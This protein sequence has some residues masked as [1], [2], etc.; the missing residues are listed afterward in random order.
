MDDLYL[1]GLGIDVKRHLTAEAAN[2]LRRCRIVFHIDDGQRRLKRLNRN[3]V[4]L[5]RLYWTGEP[6]E[7][8]YERLRQRVLEEVRRGPGV[9]YVTY[10]HPLL[11]DSIGNGLRGA[12]KLLRHSVRVIPG[13]SSL[14]TL[15]VDLGLEYGQGLQ[16]YDAT[17][18][19]R[20]RHRLSRRAHTLLFQVAGFN[21]YRTPDAL[22]RA[23]KN[24]YSALVAYLAQYYPLTH[25]ITLAYS[26]DGEYR[27]KRTIQLRDLNRQRRRLYSGATLYVPPVGS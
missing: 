13:I 4:N 25:A 26:D 12:C 9:A 5:S 19:V 10:G 17:V 11:L 21:F 20:D 22:D 16:V 2:V 7:I 27:T 6:R 24:R 23:P 18:L 3:V 14:D 15:S 8:V 1:I